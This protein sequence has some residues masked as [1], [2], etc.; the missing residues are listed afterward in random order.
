MVTTAIP[1]VNPLTAFWR[2]TRLLGDLSPQCALT[3]PRQSLHSR[4]FL[5]NGLA[6]EDLRRRGTLNDAIGRIDLVENRLVG[7]KSHGAYEPPAGPLPALDARVVG[8]RPAA[9]REHEGDGVVGDLSRA[10]VGGVAHRD[11]AR[12]PALEVEIV[13]PDAGPDDDADAL[14]GRRLLGEAGG[15]VFTKILEVVK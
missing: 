8:R 4:F 2:S 9:E 11:A 13:E 12:A 1:D 7:M 15:D 5:R 3:R 10:V 14:K 6:V